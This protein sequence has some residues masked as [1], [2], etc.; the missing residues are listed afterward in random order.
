MLGDI[1]VYKK[2]S[3]IYVT[4]LL[5]AVIMLATQ[6]WQLGVLLFIIVAGC[7]VYT[8]RCDLTQ[9]KKL[10]KYLD[11]LS[12]GVSAGTVYAVKNLP[13]GI[14]MMDSGK[15]LVWTNGVFRSWLGDDAQEGASLQDLITG[16][17]ISKIWGKTGWFDCHANGTFFRVFHKYVSDTE[18]MEDPFMVLY[19]M[20]RTDVEVAVRECADARPVFCII[21]IDNMSEVTSEMTDVERSSLS[22]DVTEKVLSYFNERDGFI[23]QYNNTDFVACISHKALVEMMEHNFD[24]LDTVRAIH[25]VNRIPV[26]LSIGVAQ[27][28]DTFAKQY[29]EAQVSLDLALGRGGDQ[30]IVRIGKDTKAFGGKAPTSVSSTRVRVRVVA[31]ALKEIIE[32][33]D[34]VLVMGHNHEDFDALGSAVGVT[35]LAR[36]SH[37][38]THIVLSKERDTCRKMAEAIEKSGEVE[39]LIIDAG[40]AKS[41][42]TDKTVLV[43]VDTHI[44]E[45]VAAPELLKKVKKRV[46]IDH[47]RRAKSIIET[48]LL[49]YMEPSASSA[50]E[51]VTELIQ[52]YGG[53]EEM[54]EIEASCLYAGIVVDTKSFTVQTSVRTFDAASYLRRCGANTQLVH[55]LF[56]EDI[57]FIQKKAQILAQMKIAHGCIAV[58]ECPKDAEESQILAGQIADYLVTVKE[59]RASFVFYHAEKGLFISARSDGSINMQVIMEAVG[60]GGHQT[61]AGAQVGD[62]ADQEAI[63]KTLIQEAEKQI[64]EEKE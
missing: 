50:S 17:K 16:Q 13:V 54:N 2:T 20:D 22:S 7:I 58:A 28:D 8:K 1:W 51:L 33:A 29:D 31:Q 10:M 41:L 18:G 25:T 6:N 39:G 48:P 59:I 47:H 9:E 60:G 3:R 4:L 5:L 45:L 44:P 63:T 14:A 15:E 62:E 43:V 36:S 26:T 23:K 57:G 19:F 11:D 56:A 27:I 53:D 42:V 21:R 38:E 40:E 64:E 55:R 24:I 30:A 46:V 34:L 35:H 32:G 12:A 52:Y 61:V 37:I 49:T